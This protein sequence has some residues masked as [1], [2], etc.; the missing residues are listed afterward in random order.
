[1]L[2]KK[3]F[4]KVSN[5]KLEIQR[6]IPIWKNL[7][8]YVEQQKINP[9]YMCHYCYRKFRS[10]LMLAYCILNNLSVNDVPEVISLHEFEKLL[11][12]RAKAF[13]TIVKMGTVINKKN[14]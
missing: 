3:S 10:G 12:Q 14:T 2:Q 6:N 11:I 8:A 13:Q 4:S 1:L 7:M 5:N 9:Q